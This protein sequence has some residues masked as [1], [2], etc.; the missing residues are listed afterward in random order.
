[1]FLL[2][3]FI[4][5]PHVALL[6][7]MTGGMKVPVPVPAKNGAGGEVCHSERGK[8]ESKNLRSIGDA[9]ILRLHFVPLRM[10]CLYEN[11]AGGEA[12]AVM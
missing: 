11:G 2:F 6:L 1:M 9:K 10:T 7:G 5:D 4:K 8:A 12:C 3:S